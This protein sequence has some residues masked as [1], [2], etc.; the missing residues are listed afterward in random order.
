VIKGLLLWVWALLGV[1]M[2]YSRV[3]TF[4][5]APPWDYPYSARTRV[6][7]AA[8]MVVLL[9]SGIGA[10][11]AAGDLRSRPIPRSVFG[12]VIYVFVIGFFLLVVR[13][14]FSDAPPFD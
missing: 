10:I 3:T 11:L 7:V 4:F 14:P 12:I 8:T 5:L 1:P 6:E 9:G 13:N 2:T